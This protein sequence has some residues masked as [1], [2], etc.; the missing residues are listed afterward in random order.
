MFPSTLVTPVP[1]RVAPE[2]WAGRSATVELVS[3]PGGYDVFLAGEA[4]GHVWVDNLRMTGETQW[5]AATPMGEHERH[6]A[7]SSELAD[8]LVFLVEVR[9][10]RV[11]GRP[12]IQHPAAT[13]LP[14]SRYRCA[15]LRALRLRS[16]A[17]RA[18]SMRG[19]R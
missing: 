1:Y 12:L 15:H 19:A 9:T 3:V 5:G 17:R 10:A 18:R 4:L 6:T 2:T 11:L 16:N 8:V 13:F 14:L 7:R